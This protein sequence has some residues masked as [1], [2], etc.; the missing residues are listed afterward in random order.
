[1][2]AL[3]SPSW[4]ATI[5]SPG[6][7]NYECNFS[8]YEI[9]Y[10]SLGDS[11]FRRYD[12]IAS[13][14]QNKGFFWHRLEMRFSSG[15]SIDLKGISEIQINEI[16]G[17]IKE[18]KKFLQALKV[19]FEKLNSLLLEESWWCKGATSGNFWIAESDL[20]HHKSVM[21]P[22][23]KFYRIP[24]RKMGFNRG[25]MEFLD[26]T[27]EFYTDPIVF[28]QKYNPIFVEAECKR[29][30]QYLDI[31]EKN[32]LTQEQR[33]A[34]VTNEDATLVVASA[35]SGKTS[36]LVGKVGYLI[37]KQLA[38]PDEI[39]I[40]AF[41]RNAKEEISERIRARLGF[42]VD[43][44]TFHSYG[45]NVIAR[46]N[47]RRPSIA[48]FVEDEYR[49]TQFINRVVEQVVK[50]SELAKEVT[51]FFIEYFRPYKDAFDF[52][53][54]GEY[55]EFI[56]TNKPI[57]LKG[58]LVKSLEE[59]ELAN[60]LYA[61]GIEYMYEAQY[62]LDTATV[63]K[64]QYRPDFYL[65]DYQIYIEHFALD[66]N[67]HTP[68]FIDESEYVD[69][70]KWKREIHAQNQTVLV[71]TYS[72]E[73]KDGTLTS[74]LKKKLESRGVE[75]N[76][77][78]DD[79]LFNILNNCG[80]VSEF[81][82]ICATF[83]NLFKGKGISF[84]EFEQSL[85]EN[86]GQYKRILSFLSIFKPIYEIYQHQLQSAHEIDFHDMIH[87]AGYQI[88]IK[89]IACNYKFLLV[90][91]FQDI[92]TGRARL[93][94]SIQKVNPGLKFLAVGDDWQS[95]YRFAGSDIGLMTNFKEYFGYTK[96]LQLSETFRFNNKIESVASKFIQANPA[97][98]QKSIVTLKSSNQPEIVLFIP[99]KKTG[100]Y[101]ELIA[102]EISARVG[103]G[104]ATVLLLARYN[105]NGEGIEYGQLARLAPN[106][107]FEFST[108]HRAKGR[109]ADFVIVL[110]LTR[111]SFGFPSEIV[112]DPIVTSILAS[113]EVFP[114]SEERRL[115]Y[116]AMTRAKEAVYLIGDPS[117]PSSFFVELAGSGHDTKKINFGKE[118]KRICPTCKSGRMLNKEGPRGLF[119]GCEYFPL[120]THTSNVCKA[121]G[122]GYLNK[123]N[124]IYCCDNELC[125]H[126][127]ECCPVCKDGMLVEKNGKFGSFYG[128]SNYS[129]TGC[130]YTKKI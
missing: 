16:T 69:S 39:L 83:L 35:G 99:N 103:S 15:G 50:K 34:V 119:F 19:E 63:S 47:D 3:I 112:D 54:L 113:G 30:K 107:S 20:V 9:Q 120:C 96:Y 125:N 58:E 104:N 70:I 126:T 68:P 5:F 4:L 64:R 12:D 53:S 105:H 116:V 7:V 1:M 88:A 130:E 81:A 114:H 36:L 121:C 72:H 31:V 37:E 21:A 2:K 110:E 27:R 123:K 18:R 24:I 57:T 49:Y 97:Q 52:K 128:C 108:V 71:E 14:S 101:L 65:P 73:K 129:S 76:P 29:Y 80:Y 92:S 40:L 61:N 38:K 90:D 25:M 124:E 118:Y 115:F 91:E 45:L 85:H 41:N 42:S 11:Q 111:G 32:S 17:T 60:Y 10:S 23:E 82:K 51:E 89:N 59:L 62:E 94:Q 100:K 13:V 28:K 33:E 22:L 74:S 87:E 46:A 122:I 79:H 6:C 56:K 109:E 44:H 77:L 67:G 127:I 43:V 117:N 8:D 75:F 95:I 93:L 55:F 66:K 48:Q 84:E 26:N 98:I 86:D 78:D 106:C 102:A